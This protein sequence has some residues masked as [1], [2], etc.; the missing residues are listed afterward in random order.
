M[1][2][3]AC[4]VKNYYNFHQEKV[5]DI[6]HSQFDYDKNFKFNFDKEELKITIE[7]CLS[8]LNIP[9]YHTTKS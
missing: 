4:D 7:K 2:M 8:V 9:K 3:K 1:K 6:R 5:N